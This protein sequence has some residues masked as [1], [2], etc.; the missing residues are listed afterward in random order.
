MGSE[1]QTVHGAL[2]SSPRTEDSSH[3]Q[4]Q[5][6]PAWDV[7]RSEH[8]RHTA[9]PA[10]KAVYAPEENDADR[11]EVGGRVLEVDCPLLLFPPTPL[12]LLPLLLLLLPPN[13]RAVRLSRHVCFVERD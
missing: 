13:F 8:L 5:L 3:V 11:L 4:R 10:Q 7:R 12:L 9:G 2:M 1:G 6:L